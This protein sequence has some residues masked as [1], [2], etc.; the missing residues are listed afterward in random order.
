M[1]SIDP[2]TLD[3]LER[4]V[5]DDMEESE[6]LHFE[7]RLTK[8]YELENALEFFLAFETQKED[9]GRLLFKNELIRID[10][11]MQLEKAKTLLPA[12]SKLSKTVQQLAELL[13]NT[14][15]EIASWFQP[16]PEYQLILTGTNRSNSGQVQTP[17]RGKDYT[18]SSLVFELEANTPFQ[19]SIENNQRKELEKHSISKEEITFS[20][21]LSDYSP[22][23]YYWK[24]VDIVNEEVLIGDFLVTQ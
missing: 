11:E 3:L 5:A 17:V 4:Y 23:L 8:D 21:H 13:D 14:L 15:D 2:Q 6:R 10:E 24:L 19:I 12:D 9:F 18:N 22:G 1:N 20:I 16:I 7:T